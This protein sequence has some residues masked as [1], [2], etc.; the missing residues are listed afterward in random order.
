VSRWYGR[1]ALFLLCAW[2]AWVVSVPPLQDVPQHLAAAYIQL[3]PADYPD[4]VSNGFLKTNS[5]LFLFLHVLGHVVSLRTAMKLFVTLVALV[6]AIAYPLAAGKLGGKERTAVFVVWP[7]VH[8]WF[9]AMGML[10]FALSV[11]LALLT[12][13]MLHRCRM[14]PTAGR[15]LAVTGLS[16]LTWYTHAFSVAMVA[17]LLA[18][19]S[20]RRWR[21]W[22][23]SIALMGMLSPALVLTW[24][25]SRVQ[26]A[27]ANP[28]ALVVAHA[29]R[30]ILRAWC[31][32]LVS[33][34]L[35]TSAGMFCGVLLFGYG[36]RYFRRSPAF[37]S[38]LAMVAL[39]ILYFTLPYH[40]HDW[41]YIAPRVLP[42]FWMG[43]ALRVTR[44]PGGALWSLAAQAALFSVGLG[45]EY[46]TVGREWD[47]VVRAEEAVP[48]GSHL[49]PM[50]F[51]KRGHYAAFTEPLLHIWGLYVVDRGTTA[52]LLFAHSRSF[53]L[54]RTRRPWSP[55]LGAETADNLASED[56]W[57]VWFFGEKTPD[58]A[59]CKERYPSALREVFWE[60]Q[61]AE[62]DHV[63]MVG[64]PPD[65]RAAFP[66][67]EAHIQYDDGRN[68][69]AARRCE[70]RRLVDSDDVV[71]DQACERN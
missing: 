62:L 58:R 56:R 46:I 42:F 29:G 49:L 13:V 26:L 33:M 60:M 45:T 15:A 64:V 35:R 18:L 4:L 71:V 31:E 44:L 41:F 48:R 57:C 65:V 28:Y 70:D 2:P 38:P 14:R 3:H 17:V 36:V 51:D 11:P 34:S 27:D 5:T 8:N 66:K 43:C 1:G 53:P 6:G 10:D 7:L 21:D 40:A 69:V 24:G 20:I 30:P 39:A 9:V 54:R 61:R 50:V 32:C 22:R 55:R 12:L 37:F 16:L 47:A 63:L 19:E 59:W 68:V 23:I 67:E 25:S 52:P